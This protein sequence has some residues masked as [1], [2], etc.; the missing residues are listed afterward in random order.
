MIF[1]QPNQPRFDS[2]NSTQESKAPQ[3]S[4]GAAIIAC[5]CI[6]LQARSAV[7]HGVCVAGTSLSSLTGPVFGRGEPL[8]AQRDSCS[9]GRV[10][11]ALLPPFPAVPPA[12][13]QAMVS[14]LL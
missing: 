3:S 1:F 9:A 12:W 10:P 5:D 6:V 4:L 11:S 8:R 13:P 7:I 2:C 14:P